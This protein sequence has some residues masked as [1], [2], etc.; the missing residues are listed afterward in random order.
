MGELSTTESAFLE[1]FR[2][3]GLEGNRSRSITGSK[4][5]PLLASHFEQG[6]RGGTRG[7]GG[8]GGEY[9]TWGP[10]DDGAGG[11]SG[12]AATIGALR[13]RLAG[14]E[15]ENKA[16]ISRSRR[17]EEELAAEAGRAD[18]ARKKLA[19]VGC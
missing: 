1:R 13:D 2:R 7:V 4:G 3:Q 19:Q 18:K 5:D 15:A 16:L 9:D 8:G 12:G 17:A 14:A 11:G 10:G 6:F